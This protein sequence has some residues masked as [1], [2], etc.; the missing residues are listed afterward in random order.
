MN[1]IL[2]FVL[3]DSDDDTDLGDED[4]DNSD[5]NSDW[6]YDSDSEENL[7]VPENGINHPQTDQF[8][9]GDCDP[10]GFVDKVN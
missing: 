2:N 10:P 1:E 6:K 4:V 9:P 7:E 3:Q 5:P 8:D